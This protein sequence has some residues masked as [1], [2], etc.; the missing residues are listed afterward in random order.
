MVPNG[1][2][3]EYV[4]NHP[5]LK[6]VTIPPTGKQERSGILVTKSAIFAGEGSGLLG[7]GKSS[8]GPMFRGYDKRTGQMI[9]EMK[10]PANQSGVPM[11]YMV[12]GKQYIVVPVGAQ[13][14]PAELVALTLP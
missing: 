14:F 3:P 5:A 7:V 6:G 2:T 12:G 13:G 9:S 10:L 1:D 8:G 4:K 11:T